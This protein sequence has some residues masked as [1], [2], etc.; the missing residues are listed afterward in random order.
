MSLSARQALPAALF[1]VL[2]CGCSGETLVVLHGQVVENGQPRKGQGK[3]PLRVVL[4][5]QGSEADKTP[6]TSFVAEVGEDGS[7]TVQ[8]GTGKGIPPGSYTF[9]LSSTAVGPGR[10]QPGE[11]RDFTDPATSPL[12]CDVTADPNQRVVIDLGKKTVERRP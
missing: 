11:L 4:T 3:P 12:K 6:G 9:T 5:G 7:F 10:P 2:C 1:L 8:G